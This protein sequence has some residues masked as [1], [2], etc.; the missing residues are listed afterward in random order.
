[1]D[2][3]NSLVI[4]NYSAISAFS[5]LESPLLNGNIGNTRPIIKQKKNLPF[6]GDEGAA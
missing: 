1:M 6:N 3:D 5:V 2:I 4:A